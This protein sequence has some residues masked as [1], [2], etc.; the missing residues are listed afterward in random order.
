MSYSVK[1]QGFEGPLDLLLHLINK[2]DLDLYDIPVKEI[3]EQYMNYIQAM[4]VM[5]LN[6]ASEYLVMAST[7]LQMKSQLLLPIEDTNWED[8]LTEEEDWTKED[9]ID[10]LAEYKRYKEAASGLKERELARSELFSKPMTDLTNY[11]AEEKEDKN[12]TID[13]SVYDMMKA[14]QN[15][16]KRKKKS[17]KQTTKVAREEIPIEARMKDVV[18]YLDLNNGAATFND[19]FEETE[20]SALVVTFLAILELM[21]VKEIECSQ[22]GNYQDIHIIKKG[23]YITI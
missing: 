1:L 22:S 4:Q 6:I 7:L 2:N 11:L 3:T 13:V 15:M 12:A 16:K 5:E 20:D 19:L 10:R 21:K 18:S 8:G 23:A 17:T 9:L 14:F